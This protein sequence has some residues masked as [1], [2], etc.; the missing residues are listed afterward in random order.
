MILLLQKSQ[1]SLQLV[2]NEF[3]E[4]QDIEAATAGAFT[5]ARANLC[6]TALIELNQKA[7]VDVMYR[8]NDIKLYKGM[9]VL[10]VDGSKVLLPEHDSVIKEFGEISY[11]NDHPDVQG[12]HAYGLA[13]SMYDVLNHVSVDSVLG[14]A[15]DY[16]VDLAI[17]H[18]LPHTR[19][20]DLLIFDR[21]YANYRL[22]GK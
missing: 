19:D 15:R 12:A 7:V 17:L 5:Q 4:K 10:G 11:S 9:R 3:F 14:K 2:L 6:C 13:S 22:S 8:D 1:K 18:H 16:E 20:N 21:N